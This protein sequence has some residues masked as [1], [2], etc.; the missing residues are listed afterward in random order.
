MQ[1]ALLII[2]SV[3]CANSAN[4]AN[5]ANSANSA[6]STS[7]K[8]LHLGVHLDPQEWPEMSCFAYDLLVPTRMYSSSGLK[9]F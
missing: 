6:N 8:P 5:C 9:I 2:H 3:N 4:S 7:H 1:I